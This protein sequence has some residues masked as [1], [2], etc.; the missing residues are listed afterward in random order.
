MIVVL[1][2]AGL[3]VQESLALTEHD[4]EHRRGSV[5]VR[6]GK[7]GRRREVGMDDWG[8]EQLRPWLAA[9]TALP[10]AP[11]VKRSPRRR[12]PRPVE[13]LP[14]RGAPR[15]HRGDAGGAPLRAGA[16]ARRRAGADGDPCLQQPWVKRSPRLMGIASCGPPCPQPG[17]LGMQNL[18]KDGPVA[19]TVSFWF[20][21]DH[22]LT[23]SPTGRA[24]VRFSMPPARR[25]PGSTPL[26][27]QTTAGGELALADCAAHRCSA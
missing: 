11:W 22:N 18:P 27:S 17:G 23:M 5:L 24:I 21:G 20:A 13:A 12:P 4:L 3:R 7:G 25:P 26:T 10:V 8:W 15:A 9:R 16:G 1:W 14:R 6:S 2:R 19:E